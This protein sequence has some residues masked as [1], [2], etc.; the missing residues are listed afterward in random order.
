MIDRIEV[1]P[2]AVARNEY[3]PDMAEKTR[4]NARSVGDKIGQS[5]DDGWLY[6]KVEAKLLGDAD[7]PVHRCG[8]SMWM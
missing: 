1:R 8:R 4:E 6:T 5:L 3:T 2:A 7:T